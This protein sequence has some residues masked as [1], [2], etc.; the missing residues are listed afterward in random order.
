MN[1]HEFYINRCIQLAKNGLGNTYPNPFVGCIIVHDD[2]VIGEGY[3]SPAGGN[4]AE[5]NA[6][7][8]VS[9]KSLLKESTLY[10]SLEPCSHFGKTPP[11]SDLIIRYGI[12][13][14]VIGSTDSNELVSGKGI[15]RLRAA[16]C[17]VMTGILENVCDWSHRRFF[18]FHRKRRPYVI[19]KWAQSQDGF[20]APLI[21][22]EK[23]PVWLSSPAS[24][25][26]VHKWRSEEQAIL[27]GAQTVIDDDPGLTTRDW[28]GSNPMRVIIDP[29]A[30]IP[31]SSKIFHDQVK[32]IWVVRE[33][34]MNQRIANHE[35]SV[36]KVPG[37]KD[38]LETIMDLLYQESIQSL[39]VEGGSKTLQRFSDQNLWDEARIFRSE[40]IIKDGVKAPVIHGELK[41]EKHYDRDLYQ[42]Y[43]NK[44][45]TPPVI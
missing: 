17:E 13:R 42:L 4:H 1:I 7:E 32:T 10:V 9:D 44:N 3:T 30:R 28:N 19:L 41:E 35:L 25:Q 37:D 31:L 11:C 18:T 38:I 22:E 40:T 33:Q 20:L 16:G 45:N 12:P 6:I 29:N 39:I 21:R 2:K 26:L 27:V 23:K 36:L 34:E 5:V 14:V 15:A 8:S 43:L 24:R